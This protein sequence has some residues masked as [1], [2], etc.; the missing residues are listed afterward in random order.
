MPLMNG[1]GRNAVGLV[2]GRTGPTTFDDYGRDDP[3]REVV[4]GHGHDNP[5]ATSR[6]PRPGEGHDDETTRRP[7][8]TRWC[9]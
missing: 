3:V 9:L 4:S 8:T 2:L 5:A 7:T 1:I 6:T